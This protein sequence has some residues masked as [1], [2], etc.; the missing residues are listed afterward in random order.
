MPGRFH[1][2]GTGGRRAAKRDASGR[3][4]ALMGILVAAGLLGGAYLAGLRSHGPGR[5]RVPG[6][7][8]SRR[9]AGEPV[10]AEPVTGPETLIILKTS[11]PACGEEDVRTLE[12]GAVL[13]GLHRGEVLSRFPGFQAE[14]FR[15]GQVVLRRVQEGPCPDDV[16]WRT[17]GLRD[18]RVVVF[19]GRPERPGAV[20]KD[21]G[22]LV[23]RL[24]PADREKLGRGIAVR[25]EDGVWQVLEGLADAE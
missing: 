14:V 3:G 24:L 5:E 25:G 9:E 10:P 21:T 13:A 15:P 18:G 8:D 16:V 4:R 2:G 23:D 17:I 20:L 7:D 19:A 11:W 22:I 1:P 6:P 12:A